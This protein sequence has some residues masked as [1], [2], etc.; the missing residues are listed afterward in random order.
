MIWTFICLLQNANNDL[1]EAYHMVTSG[2]AMRKTLDFDFEEESESTAHAIV[3]DIEL[4]F[5]DG[6]TA[7]TKQLEPVNPVRDS[8]SDMA[9]FLKKGSALVKEKWEQAERAQATA[10][11][12]ALGGTSLGNIMGIRNEEADAKGT[13][14]KIH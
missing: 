10:K 5:L 12:A 6:W 13:P 4:P 9:V 14:F 1:W 3:H 11:L 2:L 8:T 7:F